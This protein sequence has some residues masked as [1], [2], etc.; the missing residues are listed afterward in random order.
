[1]EGSS[2][3]PFPRTKRGYLVGNVRSWR[4]ADIVRIRGRQGIGASNVKMDFCSSSSST[5]ARN[6]QPCGAHPART[7]ADDENTVFMLSHTCI[8]PLPAIAQPGFDGASTP[9]GALAKLRQWIGNFAALALAGLLAACAIDDSGPV[10]SVWRPANGKPSYINVVYLTDR[11]PDPSA[12]AGFGQHWA[13]EAS[14]G[15]AETV[16]PAAM[17]PGE[18]P[19]YGYVAKTHP[20]ACATDK[21]ALAGAVA[22]IEA[23]AKARNCNSVF[24]FVHGFHTGFDGGVL[25]SAQI[26][27]DAQTGCAVASFSWSSEVKLDRYANDIEHS[28]YSEPLL[29]EFLRELAESGLQVKILAHSMG[30]RLVLA[31]LSGFARGR[32]AVKPGFIDE[33]VLVAADVGI[34]K[35][36]DDFAHLLRDAT[37]YVKRMTIYASSGDAVLV[38]SRDAHGG[39]PR[40]GREPEAALRYRA[41]DKTHIVDVID[42]SDVPADL[43]D[44]SYFAMSYEAVADMS[45]ALAGVPTADRMTAA[46]DRKPTLVCSKVKDGPCGKDSRTALAVGKDRHNRS[47]EN[48]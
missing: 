12:A 39:V 25:R 47:E 11:E 38:I 46:G 32:E 21:G 1:M 8:P 23:Q 31:T 42:A 17:L 14:C 13:D 6:P 34:E 26:S 9:G 33:L 2:F 24:L 27:H 15:V 4:I 29:A 19:Q 3:S 37:P 28:Q 7:A 45:L 40:L 16:I 48:R 30:N 36:N 10:R 22:D 35:D 44:H 18:K 41:D 20:R 43:L 5:W